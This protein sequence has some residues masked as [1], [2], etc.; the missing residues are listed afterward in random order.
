MGARSIRVLVAEDSATARALLCA[1]LRQDPEIEIVAEAEDGLRAVE[2]AKR[3]LP[4]V[5]TMDVEMPVLDGH[6]AT[7][8]IMREAPTP[9]VIVTSFDLADVERAMRALQTG[10]VA[11]VAKPSGPASAEFK[12]LA[13]DL[14]ETVKSMAD[15]KVVRHHALKP[16]PGAAIDAVR[17]PEGAEVVAIAA[18]TGGPHILREILE[19]LD[20]QLAAPVLIVQHLSAGFVDG[21]V[22]WLAAS[23][24]IAVRT[25]SH[26]E[27]ALPATAYV[28]PDDRHLALGTD[29]RLVL[30]DGPPIGRFRPSA[31]MLFRSVA[32]VA[33][34]R[35]LCVMLSGMGDD[36][37]DGLRSVRQR[38]GLIIAQDEATSLVYGMPKV[39]VG[40]GLADVSLPPQE[41]VAAVNRWTRT[42]A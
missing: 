12:R 40:E 9:V 4:D 1:I 8:H 36:G 31:N 14:V 42:L 15:V 6:T 29:R 37:L 33:G 3:L 7:A 13:R 30:L 11:L 16:M 34:R 21:F 19:G 39:V 32:D 5:V 38:G 27:E 26:G 25:A 20:P 28:A 18:S 17:A 23:A 10:A 35:S 2:L 22:R 24:S 41:I